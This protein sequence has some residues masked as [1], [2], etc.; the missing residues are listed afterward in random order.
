MSKEN[1]NYERFIMSEEAPVLLQF[2][3]HSLRVG[4]R[5]PNFALEDLDTSQMVNLR[6]IWQHGLAI[7]EFGSFT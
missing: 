2:P 6:D 4:Q 3:E 1:Y 7:I 5:A